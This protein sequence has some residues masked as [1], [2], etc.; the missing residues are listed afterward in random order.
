MCQE[1]DEIGPHFFSECMVAWRV[2]SSVCNWLGVSL[3]LPT[4]ASD[5]FVQFG[6]YLG[7]GKK[8]SKTLHLIWVV[9]VGSLWFHRNNSM[10][11]GEGVEV[12][13]IVDVAQ[14]KA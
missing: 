14:F 7:G 8:V 5:H 2:C 6:I 4:L 11:R 12:A 3:V 9:V 1:V 10:F 13:G